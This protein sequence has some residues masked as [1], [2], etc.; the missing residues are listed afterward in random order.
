MRAL[1][2]KVGMCCSF[3][4]NHSSFLSL[5]ACAG[6]QRCATLRHRSRQTPSPRCGRPEPCC[7]LPVLTTPLCGLCRRVREW[8]E[9]HPN[10]FPDSWPVKSDEAM[11][12]FPISRHEPTLNDLTLSAIRA[13]VYFGR[14]LAYGPVHS[15]GIA[16][17]PTP[18]LPELLP[19]TRRVFGSR[20][21]GTDSRLR[22][23]QGTNDV[24]KKIDHDQTAKGNRPEP[25]LML[26][27]TASRTWL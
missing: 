21:I 2:V 7:R 3:W 25:H 9:E 12:R 6:R 13:A 4:R 22:I 23:C 14:R 24:R 5:V 1:S 20:N 17:G 11:S 26:P 10:L 18:F 16:N 15:A 27:G 8:L 19:T